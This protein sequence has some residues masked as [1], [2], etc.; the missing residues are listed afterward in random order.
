MLS[1][2]SYVISGCGKLLWKGTGC[3]PKDAEPSIVYGKSCTICA[4]TSQ[5]SQGF[6]SLN[7]A[8]TCEN[9]YISNSQLPRRIG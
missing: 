6:I 8:T 1:V 7:V 3:C 5:K 2:A 9:K 4:P